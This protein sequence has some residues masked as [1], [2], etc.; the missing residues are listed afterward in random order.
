M[1]LK[2]AGFLACASFRTPSQ[3]VMLQWYWRKHVALTVAGAAG[4]F[5]PFPD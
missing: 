4:V 1:Q 5:H 2:K 3:S